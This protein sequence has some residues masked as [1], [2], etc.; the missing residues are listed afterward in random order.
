[1]ALGKTAK[2]YRDNPK[3]RQKHSDDNNS[4]KGGKYAHSKKYKREHEQARTRL[5]IKSDKVD[6]EKQGGK[7]VKRSAKENAADGGRKGAASNKR[8]NK[9]K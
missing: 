2:F 1:M 6:V 8:N 5:K 9:K 4:G 3:S 7:W